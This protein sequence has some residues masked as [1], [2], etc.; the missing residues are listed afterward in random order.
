MEIKPEH[1]AILDETKPHFETAKHGWVQDVP[2]LLLLEHIYHTYLDHRFV[3]TTWCK[4]CVIKM[5]QRLGAWYEKQPKQTTNE[6]TST[7]KRK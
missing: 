3:L 7:R 1:R 5:L 6:N 2:N 4:D